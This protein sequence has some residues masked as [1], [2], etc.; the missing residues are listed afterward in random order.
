MNGK[1]PAIRVVNLEKS[2]N[3]NRVLKGVN[4]DIA[5]GEITVIIGPS[6]SGKSVLIKHIIGL[7]RPDSGEVFVEGK[8]IFELEE[9]EFRFLRKKF[10][11]LFQQSALFDS[12]TVLE[13]ITFP[14]QEH[15]SFPAQKM[16][17]LAIERLEL[18]GLHNV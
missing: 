15:T 18:L 17:E 5:G 3:G 9:A 16:T 8:A 10:G 11:M 14:L 1:E 6:G 2:F 12:M 4:L 13:N 7:L